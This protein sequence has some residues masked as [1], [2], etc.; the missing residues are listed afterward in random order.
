MPPAR[1]RQGYATTQWA[2]CVLLTTARPEFPTIFGFGLRDGLPLEVLDG[3]GTAT[4]ERL[5]VIFPITGTGAARSPGRRAG[6]L[7]LKFPRHLTGSI[8][9][10]RK[11]APSDSNNDR[12]DHR[13]AFHHRCQND[14][15]HRM[16]SAA[17]QMMI[18][19]EAFAKS[20][21]VGTRGSWRIINCRSLSRLAKSVLA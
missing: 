7:P 2:T 16:T 4:G 17:V 5:Y 9:L 8:F 18:P 14:S 11:R 1:N 12:D 6:V 13:P 3:V 15:A 10:G 20:A 19:S 21:R